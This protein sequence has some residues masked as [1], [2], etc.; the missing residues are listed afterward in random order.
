MFVQSSQA[1]RHL[2]LRLGHGEGVVESLV[3]LAQ[4]QSIRAA[5]VSG[6][7]V[8]QS[9]TVDSYDPRMKVYSDARTFA[10]AIELLS[11]SG[12]ISRLKGEPDVHLHATIARDAGN[13][14]EVLGGRLLEAQV[15]AVELTLTVHDDLALDRAPDAGTGLTGWRVGDLR[16]VDAPARAERSEPRV[17][18]T[19]RSSPRG[20]SEARNRSEP[21]PPPPPPER[22]VAPVKVPPK[23]TLV[24]AAQQLEAMPARPAS[25][26]ADEDAPEVS[27]HDVLDHPTFGEVAVVRIPEPGRYDIKI[28]KT[29]SFR[30]IQLDIFEITR[31]GERDGHAVWRLRPRNPRR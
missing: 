23:L 31:I 22:P 19:E 2:V 26:H 30:T 29:G 21:P 17:E 8:L 13:G 12:H 11:L 10:G 1:V 28:Q 4:G 25:G 9:A 3:Q 27:V 14:I 24:E 16:A 6:H 15:V 18:R 20:G 7:G 5:T